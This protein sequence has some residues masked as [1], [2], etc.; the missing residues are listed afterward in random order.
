MWLLALLFCCAEAFGLG[1]LFTSEQQRQT[2]ETSDPGLSNSAAPPSESENKAALLLKGFIKNPQGRKI[3]WLNGALQDKAVN[4]ADIAKSQAN[5]VLID[6]KGR[7][8]RLKPGQLYD[9]AQQQV[10]DVYEHGALPTLLK[11]DAANAPSTG[12]APP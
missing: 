1:R 8:I 4:N 2:L 6:A 9:P 7:R 11:S 10:L 3:F 12:A 5:R